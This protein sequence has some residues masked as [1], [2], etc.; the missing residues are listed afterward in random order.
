MLRCIVV[1]MGCMPQG[2]DRNGHNEESQPLQQGESS[3]AN[4][5]LHAMYAM[6]VELPLQEQRD[7][8]R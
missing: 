4:A 1:N 6:E 8:M 2:L 7:K 3:T 5:D